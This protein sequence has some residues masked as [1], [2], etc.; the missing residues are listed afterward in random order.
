MKQHLIGL[1]TGIGALVPFA[2]ESAKATSAKATSENAIEQGNMLEPGQLSA[3]YNYPAA[4]KL[5]AGWDFFITGDYIFWMANQENMQFPGVV[6]NPVETGLGY[7]GKYVQFRPLHTT[8]KSGF[9]AGFG[10]QM[11]SVD[12]WIIGCEYTW[13]HNTFS[14]SLTV[15]QSAT[16]TPGALSYA[17]NIV[18][19]SFFQTLQVNNLLIGDVSGTTTSPLTLREKWEL[20][21]DIVDGKFERPYYLGARLLVNPEAGVRGM[22]IEQTIRYINTSATANAT[23]QIKY[24]SNNWGVGPRFAMRANW[25]YCIF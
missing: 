23:T 13:Y 4:Y 12:H 25:F 18:D 16:P 20:R 11:P 1:V 3:G 19:A 6:I 17:Q 5:S 8:F 14:D 2:V 22:W 7:N 9:K 24:H 10:W 15:A 21:V